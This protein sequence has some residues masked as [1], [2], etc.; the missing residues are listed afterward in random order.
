M[1]SRFFLFQFLSKYKLYFTES[2]NGWGWKGSLGPFGPS[3]L[4]WEYP[5]QGAQDSIQVTFEY[6][7][8]GDS[9]TSVGSPYQWLD[10]LT[11]IFW[12]SNVTSCVSVCAHFLLSCH[13]TKKLAFSSLHL[14]FR[15]QGNPHI[16]PHVCAK[17]SQLFACPHTWDGPASLWS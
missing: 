9:T 12:S 16:L 14:H 8:D 2:Q 6:L 13:W 5:E 7:Q 11:V 10:T 15:L 3:T 4:L 17:Y 1:I